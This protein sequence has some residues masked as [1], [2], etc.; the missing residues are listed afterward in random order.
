MFLSGQR[1]EHLGISN[2]RLSDCPQSPNCVSSLTDSE[3]HYIAPFAFNKPI[4]MEM[5]KLLQILEK[6]RG[7]KI[8]SSNENY[9]HVE[10]KSFI[11]GFVDDL[12]FFLDIDSRACHVR[13]ASR[14]GYSDLGVNRKR[15]EKIRQLFND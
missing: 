5:Q 9:L 11:L 6:Q 12:E 3:T 2:N 1:P 8:I 4:D 13:S 15:V 10:C 14:L 7:F